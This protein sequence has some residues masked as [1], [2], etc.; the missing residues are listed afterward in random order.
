[1]AVMLL[2]LILLRHGF[3]IFNVLCLDGSF[4]NCLENVGTLTDVDLRGK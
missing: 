2:H 3:A 1:M 4:S